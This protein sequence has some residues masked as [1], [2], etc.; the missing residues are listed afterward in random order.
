MKQ[1]LSQSK[2]V[3]TIAAGVLRWRGAAASKYIPTI[4]R[5]GGGD[6]ITS[7]HHNINVWYYAN[8]AN[9]LNLPSIWVDSIVFSPRATIL[10]QF[11]AV[12]PASDGSLYINV[13]I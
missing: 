10:V 5:G 11:W 12:Q 9:R 6:Y 2:I 3:E 4:Y 1:V 8:A 7:D 13:I